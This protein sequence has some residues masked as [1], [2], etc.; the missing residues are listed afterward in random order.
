[1]SNAE[2]MMLTLLNERNFLRNKRA[3]G[4]FMCI[5]PKVSGGSPAALLLAGLFWI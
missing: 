2:R 3:L 1:M 5:T 4:V